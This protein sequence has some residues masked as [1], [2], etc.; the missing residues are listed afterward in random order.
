MTASIIQTI[1]LLSSIPAAL[2]FLTPAKWTPSTISELHH[3]T[4]TLQH[5]VSA[6][7]A[8]TT[9]RLYISNLFKNDSSKTPQLPKDVKEAISKCRQ[10]V[11]KGLENKL[12]RMVRIYIKKGEN[13]RLC[14]I[15]NTHYLLSTILNLGH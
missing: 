8:S 2:G 4:Y 14:S 5:E 9:T 11:Q 10:A 7:H 13:I 6:K 15:L 1:V 3:N 12:S